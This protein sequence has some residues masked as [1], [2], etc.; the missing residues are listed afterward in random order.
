MSS[1]PP[2]TRRELRAAE[3]AAEAAAAPPPIFPATPIAPEPSAE[4]QPEAA[5]T[6]GPTPTTGS[7]YVVPVVAETAPTP[8]YV[9]PAA[10]EPVPASPNPVAAP[11]PQASA[12]ADNLFTY[13]EARV[14]AP[15]ID[16]GAKDAD[17]VVETSKSRTAKTPKAAR[18]AKEP[19]AAKE[20]KSAA[21][22]K[23]EADDK[24]VNLLALISIV[25]GVV[26]GAFAFV[27]TLSF[28]ALPIGGVALLT[29]IIAILLPGYKKL[30]SV[31]AILLALAGGG[32]SAYAQFGDAILSPE[33]ATSSVT[34][35]VTGDGVSGPIMYTY[36]YMSGPAS[37]D[38]DLP[39]KLPWTTTI[40]VTPVSE[41]RP[42]RPSDSDGVEQP[43]FELIAMPRSEGEFTCKI[44]VDGVVVAE[45]T[46]SGS[47]ELRCTNNPDALPIP[48]ETTP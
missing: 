3:R 31:I 45:N 18:V 44:T 37:T 17:D 46:S 24:G 23:P 1:T 47:E 20:P 29:A 36:F 39:E 43:I 5:P 22:K 10:A 9:P 16:L 14:T 41:M 35:S 26:S 15:V 19:K 8:S 27:P 21:K 28:A 38:S 42:V 48:D 30:I 13:P 32:Y 4:P 7:S 12:P 2:M 34:Y 25:A 6:T 40:P 33:V 11:A